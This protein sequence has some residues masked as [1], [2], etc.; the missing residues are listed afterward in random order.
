MNSFFVCF[1]PFLDG[2]RI[3]VSDQKVLSTFVENDARAHTHIHV[4]GI[5]SHERNEQHAF[6]RDASVFSDDPTLP[7]TERR[8]LLSRIICAKKKVR[9]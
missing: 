8:R 1:V 2:S 5:N 9:A 7:R 4:V 6:V 3:E